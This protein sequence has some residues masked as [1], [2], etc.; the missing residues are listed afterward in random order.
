MARTTLALAFAIGLALTGSASASDLIHIDR[1]WA[2][3]SGGAGEPTVVFMSIVNRGALP[4]RLVAIHSDA[5]ALAHLGGGAPALTVPLPPGQAVRLDHAGLHIELTGLAAP[6]EG[7]TT[8]PLRLQFELAGY[9]ELDVPVGESGEV[10]M[11]PA[12]GD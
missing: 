1:A 7:G 5:A 9:V 12:E 11:A 2:T 4:D 3:P 10:A 8:L 6:L